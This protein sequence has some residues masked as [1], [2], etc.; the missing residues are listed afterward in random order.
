MKKSGIE[1]LAVSTETPAPFQLPPMAWPVER[2]RR[3]GWY[4]YQPVVRPGTTASRVES[5]EFGEM[6]MF[7][8]YSYL[9]L[10][11]HPHIEEAAIDA[12]RR[13][14]TGS[15]GV[16]LLAGSLPIHAELEQAI[17]EFKGCEAA[18]VFS[19][20]FLA[21]LSAITALVGRGDLVFTDKLD[22]ASIIDG[23]RLSG[24][25]VVRLQHN[26]MDDLELKLSQA[27]PTRN[28]LVIADAVFSMDGDVYD[29]P[30]ASRICRRHGALLML[31]EA[32]SIGVLGR[33]GRGIEEHFGLGPDAYDIK[34]GTFSKAIPSCGGYVA[35][36]SSTTDVIKH[37]GRGYVYSASL[38]AAQAGAALGALEVMADETWRYEALRGN[39]EE[40]RYQLLNEGV[41]CAGGPTPIMPVICGDNE[42]AFAVAHECQLRGVFVQAIPAPVVPSGTARLRCCVTAVQTSGELQRGARVIADACRKF[43][44]VA[45]RQ[46][47]E[48]FHG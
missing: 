36:D 11:G 39:I 24:A 14:S 17:A 2:A 10:L 27:D 8:S 48:V 41:A 44:A 16:R 34:M 6:L 9:G 30:G 28:R 20:G 32:H 25:T 37:N 33:T 5:E 43:D 7:G 45:V 4:F 15:H 23:C 22:H 35:A 40:F 18:A 1:R 21:N 13:F 26:N 31:D 38:P 12:I 46:A 42:T 47:G 29:L 3:D 19:S